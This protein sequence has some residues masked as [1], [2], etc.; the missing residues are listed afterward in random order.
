MQHLRFALAILFSF[1]SFASSSAPEITV[2]TQTAKPQQIFKVLTF[3][4]RV[5]SKVDAVVR[6][7]SDGAVTEILKPLGSNVKRGETVA[8]LRHTDPVYEYAP[9]AVLSSVSGVISDV[10]VTKGSLV[11]KGD[12][13]LTITDPTQLRIKIEV[14][15]QDL[16]FVHRGLSGDLLLPGR[17]TPVSIAVSGVSPA[18]DPMLGT[19]TAEL[20]VISKKAAIASGM[21]GRVQF[22]VNRREGFL[23]PDY[24]VVYQGDKTFVRLVKDGK[25]NKVP[26]QLGERHQGQVE[27][28]TGL[29]AND[30][31]IDRASRFVNDGAVVKVDSSTAETKHE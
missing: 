27:V 16:N 15:A 22:Q 31:V 13:I 18:I 6:S 28:V 2:F 21:V 9:V 25:A 14:T 4:A 29:S 30:V 17:A 3:P 26:I 12:A 5:E 10:A 20:T 1:Q 7:E 24:A 23:L 8:I 11:N 19:A